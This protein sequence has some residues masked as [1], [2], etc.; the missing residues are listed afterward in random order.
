MAGTVLTPLK[1]AHLIS[2]GL[3]VLPLPVAVLAWLVVELGLLTK[4]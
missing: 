1:D 2:S 3:L 4:F